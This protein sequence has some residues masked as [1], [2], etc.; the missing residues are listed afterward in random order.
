M[1]MEDAFDAKLKAA[2]ARADAKT[3]AS[4]E[5]VEQ[6]L[7]RLGLANSQRWLILG[8]AASV[9]ALIA[10]SQVERLAIEFATETDWM[11]QVFMILPPSAITSMVLAGIMAAFGLVLPATSR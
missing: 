8:S 4:Q 11:A 3:I 1:T 7:K 9:G 10:G 5:F 6:L 2:F